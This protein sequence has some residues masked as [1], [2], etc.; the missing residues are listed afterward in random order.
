MK[1]ILIFLLCSL[2]YFSSADDF[3]TGTV[4]LFKIQHNAD[5][6]Y[7]PNNK[8]IVTIL[9]F[10]P[11]LSVVFLVGLNSNLQV[12]AYIIYAWNG[13]EYDKKFFNANDFESARKYYQY[14]LPK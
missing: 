1:Y 7:N 8:G 4:Q 3:R 14:N 13:I 2:P 5:L 9:F 12:S 6:T 10:D 11:D